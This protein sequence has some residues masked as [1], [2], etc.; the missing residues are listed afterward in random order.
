MSKTWIIKYAC[1]NCLK[2]LTF[3]TIMYSKACCPKCGYAVEGTVCDYE[4]KVV[5]KKLVGPKRKWYE[6]WKRNKYVYV[7]IDAATQD[8]ASKHLNK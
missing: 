5:R 2:P 6:F 1:S 7:G 8:W 3:S 4:K